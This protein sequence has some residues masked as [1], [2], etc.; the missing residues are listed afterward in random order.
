MARTHRSGNMNNENKQADGVGY[1]PGTQIGKYE[2]TER[3]GMGGQAIV[4]KAHDPLLDRYVAIKQISTHLAE[5]PDFLERFRKEA[6]ILAR[7]ATSQPAL[8]TI[9]ELLQEERGLFIVMEY[10][11]GNTLES[12]LSNN[13]GPVD[14]K[15]VL[16]ILWR[17]A[18]GLHAVHS[19]GVIHRD[20]KPGNIIV[21]EG[22]KV[23]IADFGVAAMSDGQT[24]MQ[25]GT[26]KYMAPELY[27]G[28]TVDARADMYSLGFIAYEMLLGRAKFNDVFAE[29]VHDRHTEALRWMKWHGNEQVKAPALNEI[30]PTIPKPLA[31]IVATMMVKN[32]DHRF[33]TMEQL[34]R[35]I[36]ASFSPRSAGGQHDAGV[37]PHRTPNGAAGHHH[38]EAAA[39]DTGDDLEVSTE[40]AG[41]PTAPLPSARM[42]LKTKLIYAGAG[43]LTLVAV[44]AAWTVYRHITGQKVQDQAVAALAEA[45]GDYKNVRYE[46]A[47]APFTQIAKLYAPDKASKGA[48]DEALRAYKD[49]RYDDAMVSFDTIVKLNSGL[50]AA[51][52]VMDIADKSYKDGIDKD[53]L[54][55]WSEAQGLF[56]KASS[57]YGIIAKLRPI[58]DPGARS[59]VR[60]HLARARQA[61][62]DASVA[63][64]DVERQPFWASATAEVEAGREYL[65]SLVASLSEMD[66]EVETAILHS[67][68]PRKEIVKYA[69]EIRPDLVV[70]GAHGHGGLKDLI[71]GNTINPVRHRLNIPILVVRSPEPEIRN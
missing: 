68:R 51:A 41:P 36:K 70:M 18:G 22:L 50:D 19:A 6:Q 21:G 47:E 34:G 28:K 10:V 71:F 63:K 13:P 42:S 26:T 31:D 52:A 49:K 20:I 7:L 62:E 60:E 2:I 9:H 4:Y 33:A 14:P 29:V 61:V 5:N 37:V 15:A 11:S 35:A 12:M 1:P 24:S 55:Q 45:Q 40:S 65:D 66:L 25:L 64:S 48:V 39:L 44:I 43:V 57:Q 3:L 30:N 56:K 17:L 58:G 54:G 23:K 67:S 46:E 69:L 59:S 32:P 53:S 38:D 27:G 8:V 16:Q